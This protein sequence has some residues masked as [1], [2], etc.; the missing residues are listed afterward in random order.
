MK[1]NDDDY[2]Y[3]EKKSGTNMT[4]IYMVLI[5]SAVALGI[6]AVVLLV[7]QS[8]FKKQGSGYAKALAQK[9]A[10]Q[11]GAEEIPQSN[12]D[13]TVIPGA[14]TSDQLDIWKLPDTGRETN[15]NTFGKNNG[16]VTN[17]TTGE[18]VSDGL[19]KDDPN[20]ITA[21]ADELAKGKTS[22]YDAA[23]K[24]KMS[25]SSKDSESDDSKKKEDEDDDKH[26]QV[27]HADGTKEMVEINEDIKKNTYDFSK[28]TYQ[29]PIMRYYD[30]GKAASWFGVDI[31]GGLGD[32]D[33]SKLKSAGCDFCMIKVGAR[34]YSS[35]NIVLD[36]SCKENIEAA[37]KAGLKVGVYF[38]SQAVSKSEAK[39]EVAELVSVI[40]DYKIQYPVAFV[41]E[42]VTDDMARIE[43]LDT[44]DRTTIAKTFMREV[45]NEGYYPVLYGD[46][47]W[48]LTMLD[49]EEL[50][51]YDVWL[52]QDSSKPDY[53]YTF[54]MWQYDSD[55]SISGISKDT[56]LIM[57]F[58][59]YSKK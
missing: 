21:T 5:M 8:S 10:M 6:L 12:S 52:A 57:S 35:G 3:G 29:E 48:L 1:L 30:G 7:N 27:I 43:M 53:P 25:D 45:E 15:T 56:A 44:D 51:D 19:S 13:Q 36:E 37:I 17:Q 2:Y 14:L 20:T 34:G 59:D 55:G 9:E 16:T 31:S 24:E 22:V 40:E 28:L 18:T 49:M 50:Q 33:F 23:D 4:V 11:Q 42:N 46:K 41:M 54:G 47:E 39:D 58:V 38:C 32:V 26:V